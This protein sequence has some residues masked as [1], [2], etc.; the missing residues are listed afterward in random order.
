MERT[1]PAF[2]FPVYNIDAFLQPYGTV[3]ESA[4][5]VYEIEV[6]LTDSIGYE[7]T[8]TFLLKVGNPDEEAF[9]ITTGSLETG[10]VAPA[11]KRC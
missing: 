7:D 2:I 6:K 3:P 4:E 5:G 8:K 11:M 10:R 1:L 9:A